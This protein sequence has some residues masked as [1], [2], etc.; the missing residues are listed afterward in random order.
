M[1][2]TPNL[3]LS[4]PVAGDPTWSHTPDLAVIDELFDEVTGHTHSGVAGEGPNIPQASVT[5]LVTALGAKQPLDSDLTAIAALAPADNTFIQ[6]SS[7]VW[8]ANDFDTRVRL[9]RLDQLAIPTA[10]VN[11]NSQ[12][13]SNLLDPSDPQ[14]ASSKA[15]VDAVAIAHLHSTTSIVDLAEFIR[16][17]IGATLVSGTDLTV[18]VNDAGDTITLAVT[19]VD[20]E[21]VR[22]YIAVALVA[23]PG[24]SIVPD[25][26]ANTITVANTRPV[27]RTM[28]N[29]VIGT[30]GSAVAAGFYTYLRVPF[31]GTIVGVSLL[32]DQPGNIVI[33]LWRDSH[34]NAPPTIADTITASA[35]PTLS[36][37]QKNEDTTLTGWNKALAAGDWIGINIDSATT[38]QQVTLAIEVERTA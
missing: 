34:A 38:V 26:A 13:I 29:A 31:A 32:A 16:D 8:V 19:G 33:D 5:G 10:S 30:I 1:A 14:D 15:Y 3:G 37:A 35:K 23:G 18:T 4:Q 12:K 28:I 22:D 11:A 24:I 9:N 20:A 25:D 2:V 36:A 27:Q 21:L 6:R 7:G 17:T